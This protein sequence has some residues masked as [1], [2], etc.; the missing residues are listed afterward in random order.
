MPEKKPKAEAAP[1]TLVLMRHETD[2][3]DFVLGIGEETF[4]VTSGEVQIPLRLVE[5]AETAGF[6]RVT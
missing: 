3:H 1:D 4:T 6:R 5:A 2:T